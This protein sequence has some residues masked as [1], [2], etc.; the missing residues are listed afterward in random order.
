MSYDKSARHFD[1]EP[2]I[3]AHIDAHTSV[4]RTVS[5]PALL[6]EV[7]PRAIA[8]RDDLERLPEDDPVFLEYR[9]T[10]EEIGRSEYRDS[11]TG[12]AHVVERDPSGHLAVWRRPPTTLRVVEQRLHG[13]GM[14][15]PAP[16]E[17]EYLCGAGATTLFRWGDDNPFDFLPDD[18]SPADAVRKRKLAWREHQAG[19][20]PLAAVWPF[21]REPNLFGLKIA[22]DPYKTDLVSAAPY[23]LG[24]DGGCCLCGGGGAFMSWFTL[25]T[26]FRDPWHD[27][28]TPASHVADEFNRLRRVIPLEG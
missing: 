27:R 1:I 9:D 8:R 21:H 25:A 24:G 26:A 23:A 20:E 3:W 13:E 5:L 18:A 14:R 16:D 19:H 4:R 10:Q 28:I 12:R 2:S 11:M 6:V 15:L 7:T 22:D 17:W